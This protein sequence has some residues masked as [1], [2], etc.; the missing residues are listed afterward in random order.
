MP[1]HT[2]A[3]QPNQSITQMCANKKK[4][5]EET[6]IYKYHIP[7]VFTLGVF[8]IMRECD[9]YVDDRQQPTTNAQFIFFNCS[10]E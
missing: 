7:H 10:W 3:A 2:Q 1:S 6:H 4:I 8:T 5:N 9:I